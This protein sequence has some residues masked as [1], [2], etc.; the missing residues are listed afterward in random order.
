MRPQTQQRG[1]QNSSGLYLGIN[2][3]EPHQC[4]CGKL[5]EYCGIHGL[6]CKR[7]AV[8]GIRHHQLSDI[9]RR[10]LVRANIPSVL[11]PTG[12]SRGDGKRP[13]DMTLIPWHGGKECHLGRHDH[14]Y[15]HR[16]LSTPLGGMCMQ[17]MEGAASRKKIKYTAL[18]H[19]YTFIPLAFETYR[20]I[21][22]KG[23][24]FLQE[25]GRHLRTINSDP[26]KSAFLLQCI[27]ITMPQDRKSVV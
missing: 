10:I 4:P 27:S 19:S 23:T 17:C 6:S 20:L 3:C 8:T 1:N 13:D 16:L 11:E 24:K 9:V 15:H 22:N 5:V 26:C 18:D 14:R 25:L 21:N 12:L 7:G 2:M